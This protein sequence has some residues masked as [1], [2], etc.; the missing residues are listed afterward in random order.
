MALSRVTDHAS[1]RDNTLEADTKFVAELFEKI[2]RLY[3][4]RR[5]EEINHETWYIFRAL[6]TRRVGN[7]LIIRDPSV[8]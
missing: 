6:V 2:F 4:A 3:T 5:L 7:C 8:G 1:R